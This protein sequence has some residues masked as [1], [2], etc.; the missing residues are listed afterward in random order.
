MTLFE[1]VAF[2]AP[3]S[4]P[5]GYGGTETQWQEQFTDRVHFRYLRGGET[6]Q[7]ARLEGKQ[8][9]VVTIRAHSKSLAV[10]SDYRMRDLR[11]GT[12]YN[13]RTVIPSEDRRYIEITAE[14]GVAV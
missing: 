1:S 6:V 7:A 11:R 13:I 4:A 5:D 3:V 9:V 2:D 12:A 8:P 14:S 10:T